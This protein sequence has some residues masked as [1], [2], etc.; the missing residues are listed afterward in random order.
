MP[1]RVKITRASRSRS[2]P[3]LLGLAASAA[4]RDCGSSLLRQQVAVGVHQDQLARADR[5]ALGL[6]RNIIQ[7]GK[8]TTATHRVYGE[9]VSIRLPDG[10]GA[11]WTAAGR[12]IGFL[13]RYTPR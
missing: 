2:L 3:S 12:F 10:A 4:P 13:E 8:V 6:I 7:N 1:R 11:A 9:V 5:S